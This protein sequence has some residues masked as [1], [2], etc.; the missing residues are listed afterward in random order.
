MKKFLSVVKREYIQRVRA[1]MFIVSTILLPI[2][3]SLFALVPAIILSIETPPMRIAIVDQTGR[4]YSQVRQALFSD[5]QEA[6]SQNVNAPRT[7]T[8][9]R[10]FSRFVVE[11]VKVGNQSLDQIRAGL[12][13][14]LRARE[15]DG[16]LVL[17]PDFLSTGEAEFFNRNPGDLFSPR[18]LQSA[19]NR[20]VREQRL[21]DANV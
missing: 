12:D 5:Q 19:I 7:A 20:A 2:V 1:K 3:M 14:R 17:Q 15:L 9:R 11:E 8:P 10:N 13:Q 21:I 6:D 18:V 16:Y 4:M